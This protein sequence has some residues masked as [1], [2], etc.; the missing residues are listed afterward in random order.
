[1]IM[2]LFL[3]LSYI[4][5][6][7]FILASICHQK[8]L[9]WNN[10]RK[11]SNHIS[12][13]GVLV[14]LGYSDHRN[15]SSHNYRRA[16]VCSHGVSRARHCQRN[17]QWVLPAGGGIDP[18]NS[19]VCSGAA[20][21]QVAVSP[22]AVSVLVWIHLRLLSLMT[23]PISGLGILLQFN[24]ILLDCIHQVHIFKWGHIHWY[25]V[26]TWTYCFGNMF[27]PTVFSRWESPIFS[28]MH[29]KLLAFSLDNP[30]SC[31]PWYWIFLL[32]SLTLFGCVFLTVLS[33]CFL[34]SQNFVV[35][36]FFSPIVWV[37]MHLISTY[38]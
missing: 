21:A 10:P 35:S 28:L 13:F 27:Q 5:Q 7:V 6:L 38:W 25:E 34:H 18:C 19:S 1:M 3:H 29:L 11:F 33:S 8:Q 4:S 24:L 23:T 20:S 17:L 12:L 2:E 31:L 9:P 14:S 26:R 37:S 16:E 30:L 15:L 22:L 36:S 32:S